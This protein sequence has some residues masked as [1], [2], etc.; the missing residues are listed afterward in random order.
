[1]GHSPGRKGD[2][3]RES[4]QEPG[5]SVHRE[6]AELDAVKRRPVTTDGRN[7]FAKALER[8]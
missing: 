8:L 5:P 6:R 3:A 1:M 2:Q 7:T 4:A